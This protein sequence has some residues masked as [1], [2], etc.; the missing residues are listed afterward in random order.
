[1]KISRLDE[2]HREHF[3][4]MD[5]YHILN[6]LKSP[7]GF[8]LTAAEEDPDGGN[9]IPEGLLVC[10]ISDEILAIEWIFVEKRF[11]MQ[12]VGDRLLSAAVEIAEKKHIS[13]VSAYFNNNFG[14]ELICEGA[15]EYFTE[16][17][18]S[19]DPSGDRITPDGRNAGRCYTVET[20]VYQ[21]D[22][23]ISDDLSC[24]EYCRRLDE[25]LEKELE[26]FEDA[27]DEPERSVKTSSEETMPRAINEQDRIVTLKELAECDFLKADMDLKHV[28]SIKD[29]GLSE[30]FTALESCNESRPCS[31]FSEN[32]AQVPVIWFEPDLSCCIENDGKIE[33][34]F[35]VHAEPSG[36]LWIEYLEMLSSKM[37]NFLVYML[38]FS[39]RTAL[40]KYPPETE[41]V[42]RCHSDKVKGLTEKLFS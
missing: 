41:V 4:W 2:Q 26:T 8:A 9:E 18:F 19:N 28:K 20:A 10:T 34:L 29:V 11:R 24:A 23:K 30:L 5:P 17:L 42:I 25:A 3:S 14:H 39:V 32:I 31:W 35:L 40:E 6:L 27:S 21:S 7:G 33:G 38:K 13:K 12:G 36:R 1:M 37:T 16:H 22:R 15:E